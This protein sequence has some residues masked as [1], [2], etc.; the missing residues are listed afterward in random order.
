M[1]PSF[2]PD[3]RLHITGNVKNI[4]VRPIDYAELEGSPPDV[5]E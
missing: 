2:C 1:L 4:R 5:R 3:Y